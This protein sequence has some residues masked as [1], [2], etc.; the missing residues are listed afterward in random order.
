MLLSSCDKCLTPPLENEPA[1]S[2]LSYWKRRAIGPSGRRISIHATHLGPVTPALNSPCPSCTDHWAIEILPSDSSETT[3]EKDT[4]LLILRISNDP[5]IQHPGE[6]LETRSIQ[7]DSQN[8]QQSALS[9]LGTSVG[10]Y[11][12]RDRV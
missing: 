4:E 6:V 5:V 3:R 7:S 8:G 2:A 1:G 10:N 11:P 12:S 9:K